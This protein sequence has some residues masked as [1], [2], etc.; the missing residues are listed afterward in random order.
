[1]DFENNLKKNNIIL[2]KAMDPVGSYLAVR[3]SNNFLKECFYNYLKKLK[4]F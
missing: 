1:M 4:H 2:P 3:I